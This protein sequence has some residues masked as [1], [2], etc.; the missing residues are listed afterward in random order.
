MEIADIFAVNKADRPGADRLRNDIEL[1]LGL[2]PGGACA[3]R[4]CPAHH[5]V[6]LARSAAVNGTRRVTR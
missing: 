1:M 3:G 6:D 5:G 2:R 4:T